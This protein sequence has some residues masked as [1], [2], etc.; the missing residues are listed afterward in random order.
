MSKPIGKLSIALLALVSG[1]AAPAAGDI[2]IV[3]HPATQAS[4]DISGTRIVW[5]DLRHEDWE[6]YLYDIATEQETRITDDPGD[7]LYPSVSGTNI[8][9]CDDRDGGT[10]VYLHDLLTGSQRPIVV[11]NSSSFIYCGAHISGNRIVWQR[12]NPE[13][14]KY[15]IE[16][17]DLSTGETK[18]IADN[19]ANNVNPRIEGDRIVW[20]NENGVFLFDL[21]SGSETALDGNVGGSRRHPDASGDDVVWWRGP[22]FGAPWIGHATVGSPEVARLQPDGMSLASDIVRISGD[23]VVWT[24]GRSADSGLDIYAWDLA[25]EVQVQVTGA[26]ETQEFPAIDGN[27]VVWVDH[28]N[29]NRDIYLREFQSGPECG[30][31]EVEDGEACDDGNTEHGDCCAPDCQA[32]PAGSACADDGSVCTDDLCDGSGRCA[33]EFNT[34]P[35]DDGDSCTRTDLCAGGLC[36][37]TD[38][39]DCSEGPC[40]HAGECDAVSGACMRAPKQDGSPCDDGDACTAGDSCTNGECT[41]SSPRSCD[42]GNPC[43]EDA[44]DSSAG[45]EY[46]SR[47]GFCSDDDACTMDDL[48]L[49]GECVGTTRDC[50]DG[51]EC[52][53]NLCDPTTGTCSNPA[54]PSGEACDDGV[55]CTA[56]DSCV[57]ASCIGGDAC[58]SRQWCSAELGSCGVVDGF[59]G[60]PFAVN[61][62]RS[63]GSVWDGAPSVAYAGGVGSAVWSSQYDILFSR[64]QSSQVGCDLQS[65]CPPHLGN[66]KGWEPPRYL[67]EPSDYAGAPR[68][69]GS[70][71][72]TW[73]VA[74]EAWPGEKL[75]ILVVRSADGGDTWSP[76]QALDS[77]PG[78]QLR[79][80]SEPDLGTDGKGRWLAVWAANEV[81]DVGSYIMASRSKDD[82]LSWSVPTT[83]GRDPAGLRVD[84]QPRIATNGKGRWMVVWRGELAGERSILSATSADGGA[85]WSLPIDVHGDDVDATSPVVIEE[86]GTW[87]VVW[88]SGD[89]LGG[90]LGGDRDV[91]IATSSD[92]PLEG[93]SPARALNRDAEFDSRTDERPQI[94]A[95]GEGGWIAAWEDGGGDLLAARSAA[96]GAHWSE[97]F[98]PGVGREPGAGW[99]RTPC[100]TTDSLGAWLLVW[101]SDDPL[102]GT[103]GDDTDIL[104]SGM[105]WRGEDVVSQDVAAGDTVATGNEGASAS[106]PLETSVTAANPGTVSIIETTRNQA[107]PAGY[108]LLGQQV[109]ISAPPSTPDA[110]MR[111][112]FRIDA[113][114]AK[115]QTAETIR[116]FKVTEG[117]PVMVGDCSAGASGA[118]PDPCIASRATDGDD[119]VLEI[120]TSTASDWLFAYAIR[121]IEVAIDVKPG[122]DENPINPGSHGLVPVAIL[123]ESEFDAGNVDP[124]SV[125][126]GRSGSEAAASHWDFADVD[127]DGDDDRLLHFRTPEIGVTC[128]DRWIRL[129]GRTYQGHLVRGADA[130]IA[131]NCETGQ[132]D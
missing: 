116:V 26:P 24:D 13:S 96:R 77:S 98:V 54:K 97:P 119:I 46:S 34:A 72:G 91:L 49:G 76:P 30:N 42:D 95:D 75:E 114:I 74:W 78:S 29:G 35:C 94:A 43:T 47:E 115:G 33:H 61:A 2:P 121:T 58:G 110:P 55:G 105:I 36:T 80:D 16:M 67:S 124:S 19:A 117:P 82:G 6:I 84:S 56:P 104:A 50:S 65:S 129:T 12:W 87:A 107:P 122:S 66:P 128:G 99:D 123:S 40:V 1:F 23:R 81:G 44:C 70:A 45:C 5:H 31:G 21:Q 38:R 14:T 15:M 62:A 132:G 37:G 79:H 57:A 7:Q 20:S 8:V 27:R 52:T 83:V 73:V 118:E 85:S 64:S 102:A 39:V 90:R 53:D 18:R 4:P 10:S 111:I 9:W 69:S 25:A 127:R 113:S 59:F 112:V 60:Q 63:D 103:V 86:G 106:D 126:F 131:V 71:A 11:T 125:R 109:T 101:S 22:L 120:L 130:V 100:L 17:H 88:S 108:L 48:C 92:W 51:N 3:L 68:L 32:E 89:S 93:W 28:R 41:F